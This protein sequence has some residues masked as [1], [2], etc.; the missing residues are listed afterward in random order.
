MTELED[1]F[2]FADGSSAECE[3]AGRGNQGRVTL[4]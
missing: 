1:E 3:D 2:Q 4:H